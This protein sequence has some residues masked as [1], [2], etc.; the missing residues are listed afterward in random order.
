MAQVTVYT[1]ARMKEIEDASVV[2]GE[3]VGDNLILTRFDNT[4]INAGNVRGAVGPMN[5]D[6]NPA[7]TI[8]M[9]GWTANFTGYLVLNGQ[10]VVGGV[11]ANPTVAS[12]YPGWVSGGNLVLPNASGAV[13]LGGTTGFG[14][15]AGS[16][17]HTLVTANVPAHTHNVNSHSHTI[18][19]NHGSANTVS[20]GSH[21]HTYSGTTGNSS[22][23]M[24]TKKSSGSNGF[25]TGMNNDWPDAY[26]DLGPDTY[27]NGSLPIVQV[28]AGM[29]VDY[30]KTHTHSFSGTSSSHTGHTH[31]F[32]MPNFT[33]SSGSSG[34]AT[35]NGSGS[36][37]PVDHTPRNFKVAFAVKTG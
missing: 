14:V 34:S 12:M 5:P 32:D 37:T 9:G 18:D 20:G 28:I 21:S 36:S 24:V 3:V 16:M 6:G 23:D 19:H 7:G 22:Q 4:T 10:T 29:A 30:G 26:L 13:P 8:I 17:Q 1:A 15:L 27:P 11:A 31:S 35:D 33:G 25:W 2:D